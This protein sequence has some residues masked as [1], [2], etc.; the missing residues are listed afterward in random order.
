MI[1]FK[2]HN[3]EINSFE[4]NLTVRSIKYS[5]IDYYKL[6]CRKYHYINNYGDTISEEELESSINRDLKHTYI[7]IVDKNGKPFGEIALDKDWT[8]KFSQNNY[9]KPIYNISTQIYEELMHDD[10]ILIIKLMIEFLEK[11]IIKTKSLYT[12]INEESKNNYMECYLRN[13][14]LELDK[15]LFKSTT[16]RF[17][18]KNNIENVYRTQK[19]LIR[20]IN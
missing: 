11:K 13:G 20:E 9:K 10:I 18:I 14:F 5:D 19:I 3:F 12:F 7:F 17:M 1:K 6:W 4:K 16:E 2:E 15:T 8:L